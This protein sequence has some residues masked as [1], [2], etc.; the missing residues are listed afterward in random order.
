MAKAKKATKGKKPIKASKKTSK[1]AKK[2]SAKKPPAKKP[3]KKPSRGAAKASKAQATV[4][5]PGA[6]KSAKKPAVKQAPIAT[7]QDQDQ[8]LEPITA[9]AEPTADSDVMDN[10]PPPSDQTDS[11]WDSSEAT[12]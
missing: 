8:E 5:K 9:A 11:G 2:A 3:V 4:K 1:T 6:K 10:V 12:S 7:P